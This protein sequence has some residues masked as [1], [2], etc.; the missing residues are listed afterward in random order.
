MDRPAGAVPETASMP[1]TQTDLTYKRVLVKLS[2]EALLGEKTFG[3][4]RAFADYVAG[5]LHELQTMKVEL[6]VVVGL[7]SKILNQ[8]PE[9]S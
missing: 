5:E 1:G 7:S 2:G 6:A 3:I 4:D 8:L 9:P